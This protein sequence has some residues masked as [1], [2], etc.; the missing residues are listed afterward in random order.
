MM[1]LSIQISGGST[2][3]GRSGGYLVPGATNGR[4]GVPKSVAAGCVSHGDAQKKKKTIGARE[5]QWACYC[6]SLSTGTF[7]S[8]SPQVV[9]K[10]QV[11]RHD[12]EFFFT[13]CRNRNWITACVVFV[14]TPESSNLP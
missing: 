13:L 11:D 10:A 9:E 3:G 4:R 1:E 2:L 14:L 6:S 8:R 7:R 5:T 12:F